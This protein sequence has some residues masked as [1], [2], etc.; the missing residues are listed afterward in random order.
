MERFYLLF[1]FR[2]PVFIGCLNENTS[3]LR[4]VYLNAQSPIVELAEK[5]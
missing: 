1:V 4:P 2:S 3:P 5:D